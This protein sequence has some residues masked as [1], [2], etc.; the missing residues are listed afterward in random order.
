MLGGLGAGQLAQ[1]GRALPY[2]KDMAAELSPLLHQEAPDLLTVPEPSPR[3]R[4][5][6][7][8]T[9]RQA[10]LP[11][12]VVE[13]LAAVLSG[14]RTDY[15]TPSRAGLLGV[16]LA[17]LDP[18]DLAELEPNTQVASNLHRGSTWLAEQADKLPGG[19]PAA[20]LMYLE[21]GESATG[22]AGRLEARRV[23][24]AVVGY[25]TVRTLERAAPQ[26]EAAQEA[27]A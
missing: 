26:V 22:Q 15:R 14:F 12:L 4:Q 19:L 9:A 10:G 8:S 2:I 1:L 5:L 18:A 7:E 17:V 21:L 27:T 6:L 25:I 3:V 13:A 24:S 23:A 16:P 20:L 11:A